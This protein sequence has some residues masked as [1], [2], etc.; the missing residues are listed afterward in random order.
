MKSS[1]WILG[2]VALGVVAA[3]T[4]AW[5]FPRAHPLYPRDWQISKV[6]AETIAVER[7]RDVGQLPGDPYVITIRDAEPVVEHGLQEAL[8]SRSESEVLDSRL[9]QEVI[10]WE[11]MVWARDARASDWS[12][13]ARV[14]AEG[15]LLELRRRVPPE[16]EGGVIDPAEA[17]R[18][19]DTFL[20]E[21]G[22]DLAGFDEPELRT[23]QLQDRTDTTLRYRD[24]EGLLGEDRPYGLDVSFAGEQLTGFNS[25]FDEPDRIAI[26]NE[27]QPFLLLQ[28]AWIFI[29]L[30]LLPLVAIPFVRRY[31][32][33]EIGVRRGLHVAAAVVAGGLLTMFFAG[34]AV[35]AGFSIGVLTKPQITGVVVF[36]LLVLFFFP[37]ALMTFLSW[38]VGESICRERRGFRLA[39][40]DALFRGEWLNATFARASLIGASAGVATAA[41][42][43]LL[44]YLLQSQ[45]V[46]TYSGFLTGPWWDNV[47]WFSIPLLGFGVSYALYFGV[48]GQLLL[49]SQ[50]TRLAGRWL[51]P[52]LAVMTGSLL[53]F[54]V[55]TVFPFAWNIPLWL[56]CPTIFVA[57]FL[58][59]GIFTS[60]FAYL[61]TFVVCGALPFLHAADTSMQIQAAIALLLTAMPLLV[62]ARYLGSDDKFHYRYEDIPPHVR[63]I[64]ERERQKVELETARRIQTSILP[65]LPP[66]LLGIKMAHTYLP[67]T[68]VGGDFYD[69]LALEDGR[70]AVAVGDVAGHG[71]SSGLVMSMAKSALTV[72]VSFNP[73][74]EAVFGTLNRMVY[75][76][77]RKRLLTTLCYALIDP[78]ERE[79][80]F[81]SA[82]HLFPYRVGASG[83]VEALESISYPLGVRD[84]IEVRERAARLESGDLLFMFS[85][86][87][88]EARPENSEEEFG[89]DRLEASLADYA[90]ASVEGMRDG[91][92]ADLERF[93]GGAPRED[94]LTVLV[95]EI[96]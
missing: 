70:L 47:S 37:M 77:A 19:A 60:V 66:Q 42:F 87:V 12:H 63:R 68:E 2:W 64:A 24:R 8:R 90:G 32:A 50:G 41:L 34:R 4:L 6:E 33:G 74:V 17:R 86:G 18:Q 71:V 27:F 13:R 61:T 76:S 85:D 22:F 35:G 40:F 29:V 73:D 5:V 89:F 43:N 54:P 56:L 11:V 82:G 79:M 45:G 58:R 10:T 20:S 16:E 67:A 15:A 1:R 48:F 31:H 80:T 83:G 44:P 95:L 14:S 30:L 49:V 88:I 78:R 69:V 25:Y 23:Q 81:A 65:E 26:Q 92:L 3:F 91:V 21:E 53:F 75:Q 84:T 93:T 39:A 94:D 96:P 38:S 28:Q 57:L 51:G 9:A 46:R 72:Q 62:S 52:V 55:T 59:Y 7:M 36:Q